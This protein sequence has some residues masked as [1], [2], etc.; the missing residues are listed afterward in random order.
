VYETAKLVYDENMSDLP[1]QPQGMNLPVDP[2]INPPTDPYTVSSTAGATADAAI[3]NAVS[4]SAQNYDPLNPPNATGGR[5]G[6]GVKES[7][8]HTVN[9]PDGLS[10]LA[11][12]V[13]GAQVVDVEKSAEVPPEV[14]SWMEKVEHHEVRAPSQVVVADQTAQMPTGDY[15]AQPVI[16]LPVTQQAVQAGMK[17][18]VKD[19][20]RWLAEWCVKMMKKFHGLVVYRET[21]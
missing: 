19:S 10:A 2:S 16:V 12:E 18:S 13:P 1:V 11:Q 15:A 7:V 20:I 21:T 6:L 4:Q 3:V 14:E 5:S 17:K 9:E 8:A